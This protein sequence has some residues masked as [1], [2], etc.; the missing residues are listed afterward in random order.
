[1]VLFGTLANLNDGVAE[2]KADDL[3]SFFP[4][5][6]METGYDIIF[7]LVARMIMMSIWLT[8]KIPFHVVYLHGLVRDKDGRRMSKSMGNV[9]DPLDTIASYGTDALGYTLVTG[10]TP[11]QDIPLSNENVE[12]NRN[13]AN[14][15]WNASRY[16]IGNLKDVSD[17]EKKE[18]AQIGES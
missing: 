8:G 11:G 9:I 13:F 2:Q 12:A 17:D 7:F 16:V 18:L 1:M 6:V 15:L 5:S 10:S 4:G 14:K 3:Q